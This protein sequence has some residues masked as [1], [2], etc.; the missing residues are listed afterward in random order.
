MFETLLADIRYAFRW[1]RKSPAFTL[2]AV[3]SFAIGIGFNTALFTLVDALLFRPLP[4]DRP[5]RLVD[6]YTSSSD[7]DT[8]ATSAYPDFVDWKAQNTVFSDLMAYSP[9]LAAMSLSDR[10]RLVMG[11]IVTGNY[12]Q[13]LGVTPA[14]GRTLLPEDDVKGAPRVVVLSHRAWTRDFG[15]SA[16]AIGQTLRIHGQAYSIVGV[17]RPGLYRMRS[18]ALGLC[19]IFLMCGVSVSTSRADVGWTFRFRMAPSRR[20]C[21]PHEFGR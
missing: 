2:L 5:D 4:V 12:F 3:A 19:W 20:S 21:P 9:T 16:Q 13:V 8:Y 6:I 17:A 15:A 14:L 11:E 1:L 10:S 7:G 18:R